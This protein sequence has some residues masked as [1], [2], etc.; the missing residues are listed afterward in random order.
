MPQN[1]RTGLTEVLDD[2]RSLAGIFAERLVIQDAVD[3]AVGVVV[4]LHRAASLAAA[5]AAP[6]SAADGTALVASLDAFVA[7]AAS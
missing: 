7:V 5:L 4:A 3:A 2:A 1:E 6:G